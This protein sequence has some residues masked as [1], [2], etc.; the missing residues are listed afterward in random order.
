MYVCTGAYEG[1]KLE[2]AENTIILRARRREVERRQSIAVGVQSI[3]CEAA[4]VT[5][6][7]D[8]Q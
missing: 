1:Q 4:A 5:H 8:S 6:N 2:R 3:G 7:P